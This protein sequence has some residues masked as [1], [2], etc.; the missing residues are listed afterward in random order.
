MGGDFNFHFDS[1]LEPK[2]G[3]PILKKKSLTKL[4]KII[5]NFDICDNWRIR[6]PFNKRYAM[7]IS[8]SLRL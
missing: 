1:N 7:K 3:K 6:N 2:G 5:K 8:L 4:R